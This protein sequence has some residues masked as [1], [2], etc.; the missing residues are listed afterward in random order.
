MRNCVHVCV[1]GL[2][3]NASNCSHHS[4]ACGNRPPLVGIPALGAGRDACS[5][6][7]AAVV[8]P[9]APA[10]CVA[11]QTVHTRSLLF[12]GTQWPLWTEGDAFGI[13]PEHSD[14][15]QLSSTRSGTKRQKKPLPLPT[16]ANSKRGVKK[17]TGTAAKKEHLRS[18]PSPPNDPRHTQKQIIHFHFKK[19]KIT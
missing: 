10:R 2:L 19:K 5:R 17:T 7:S 11:S 13:T 8:A 4:H 9:A 15:T 3:H 12:K 6:S 16:E 14:F 18:I 1:S